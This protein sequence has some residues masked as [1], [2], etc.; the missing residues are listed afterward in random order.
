MKP[1]DFWGGGA[2]CLTEFTTNAVT[3]NKMRFVNPAISYR[4]PS[5]SYY[6]IVDIKSCDKY[7]RNAR[8]NT[9]GLV[10]QKFRFTHEDPLS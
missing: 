5:L 8:T 7:L 3:C 9:R 2:N 1:T 6:K 4:P 10:G